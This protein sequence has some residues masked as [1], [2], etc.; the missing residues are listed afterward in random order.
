MADDGSSGTAGFRYEH[1]RRQLPSFPTP[2]LDRLGSR[3]LR[4]LLGGF[5]AFGI[6]ATFLAIRGGEAQLF[7]ELTGQK[8]GGWSRLADVHLLIVV[9]AAIV[10]GLAVQMLAEYTRHWTELWLALLSATTFVAISEATDVGR[11]A[12]DILLGI[13]I[14]SFAAALAIMLADARTRK[15]AGY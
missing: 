3:T 2:G 13:G 15:R 7:D 1:A 10:V 5:V 12:S 6:I 14:A 8:I 9:N 11:A 4:P